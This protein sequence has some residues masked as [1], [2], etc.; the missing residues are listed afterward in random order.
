[1]RTWKFFI[2]VGGTFTDT[3]ARTPDGTIITHKLL[4]SGVVRGVAEAG[5]TTLTV[6]DRRRIGDPDDFWTGYRLSIA[7]SPDAPPLVS[8]IAAFDGTTGTFSFTDPRTFVDGVSTAP[9]AWSSPASLAYE[10]R[11][12]EEAPILAIR[13]L[14]RLRLTDP[15]GPVE[16]RLGTTRATNALLERK[17]ARVALVTTKGFADILKIGYQDRPHLFKL[18]IR[19]RA[20]LT[21]TVIEIDE[22][23]S[24]TGDVLR[25]PDL[26]TVSEQ[27]AVL[28]DAGIETLAICLLHAHVNPRHEELIAARAVDAGFEHLSVS[29]RICRIQRIVPR[30]D[31]TVVD[32]YLAPILR[33]YVSR[34]RRS[35]AE[36]K[37][38]L[39]TSNGG[40][41]DANAVA[42]K[43]TILSGPAGGVVGCA[44]VAQQAGLEKTIAFDMGGTSTDVSRID[45]PPHPFQYTYETVKDGVRIMTPML[46]VETVAAGGGSICGFDGQKL[47]VGP[48]SA[49]ADPGPA[50]YGRGGPLTVTDM[51]LYLGR[52][53]P[54]FFPFPLDLPAV[55]KQLVS[56]SA[57]INEA[58]SQE[59][60][61]PT[62][63]GPVELAEGFVK[64]AN[65][66]MAAAVKRISLARGIDV[67]DYA[68][69]S[70][71]GAGA[72]HACA[73]AR[74]LGI[75]RVLCSPLAGVLSALGIGVADIKRIGQQSVNVPL[76]ARA[77]QTL[78]PVFDAITG[79][80][81]RSMREEKVNPDHLR[82]PA[83]TIDLC[84]KDQST[85]ITVDAQPFEQTQERFEE[86]HRQLYGYVHGGRPIE[87]RVVR[88]EQ[89]ARSDHVD[90]TVAESECRMEKSA[91]VATE[92]TT[93]MVAD[94]RRVSVP[95][96]LRGDLA[97]GRR[98][99][100]P[101]VVI[102]DT[103]TI[104]VETGWEAFVTASGD[105]L[106]TDRKALPAHETV[107]TIADPVQL[108][109]FTNQFAAAAEQMGTTLRRTAL[110]VN[111]K[112][113][114]DFS[115]AIFTPTGDLVVNA[116]HIP[117][118]LGG[119]SECVRMLMQDVSGFA[120]GDVY[121]TNDPYRGGSHLNDI[122][123]VTPVHDESGERL[124][125]V[126]A[127]RAHHAE[128][129][130]TRPGSM[131]PDSTS[132][133]EEG[134]LIRAFPWMSEG[135]P[136]QERFRGLLIEAPYPSRMPDDNL[137]DVAAQIAANQT[138]V[139]E[140]T[141]MIARYGVDVVHS[142]MNHLQAA[143]ESKMRQ[144]LADLPDGTYPFEDQL[145]DGSPIRL[146]ITIAG[147]RATFDFAGTGPVL[148]GNLNANRA[149]VTSATLYCLRCLIDEDIPLNAGVLAP[150]ELRLPEC[151]LNPP[152]AADAELCA[153]V[154][155]GNVET[156][157]RIVDAIFGALGTVAASQGTMNNLLMGNDQFGYYETICGG[158]GA[159]PSFHGTDAVHTHMTNTRLTDPEVLESR[160]PVRLIRFAIRQQSGG[161]GTFSGGCGVIREIEFLDTLEVSMLS[162]RRTTRPYGRHGG[163]AGKPGRNH[164]RRRGA[165]QQEELP[166]IAQLTA[167][168]G[169]R[170]TI[171]T[172]GGG[173]WGKKP[174]KTD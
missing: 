70:F 166:S 133:A 91:A 82:P 104:V 37:L 87:V 84:Y 4:S 127:S 150:I 5:S 7:T 50:S 118:H 161:S 156:S 75:S 81:R 159:G 154:V 12:G 59:V 167:R 46:G 36:A 48:H 55:E 26:D 80:L 124:L 25:P 13:R 45:P 169:D 90:A 125:F 49:G 130:G 141:A 85:F 35:M 157:Q 62:A 29:S 138:G 151:F 103:S 148:A 92:R 88:V 58:R 163:Q 53:V 51:N 99:D 86:L 6:R 18:D 57:R 140:L 78:E 56:L 160:V 168:T 152:S 74:T 1:M 131:P 137:A 132:L 100:G 71:G 17:G 3:V 147:D 21:E 2:D 79:D 117:V 72:Q 34:L 135:K 136:Q 60:D 64:I 73:I 113:R 102:E 31:T 142:Y 11:S 126:V 123:V 8:N 14:M 153:A 162:Q 69:T 109:L 174:V 122:T 27:L 134:V 173:G 54:E 67:R 97:P 145:D 47:T 41:I 165:Q 65:A 110:S 40:L 43:D 15:I 39:M 22:R 24:A 149:I 139:R 68:L 107:S 120:P 146:A 52:L 19:K 129:G 143:A 42:G 16:V 20:E 10:L 155:G 95:I 170:L 32:A 164:L 28:K 9:S 128:I 108:E 93:K 116:P 106:M 77:P 76:D 112:E 105:I 63:F 96:V 171:E 66:K 115:C 144:A 61:T 23:I 30:A 89:T 94:S 114:L 101:A 38:H 119:M 33:D 121:I 111:V 98:I 158:S 83:R 44:H 172:P